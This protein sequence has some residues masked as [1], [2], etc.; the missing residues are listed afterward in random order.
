MAQL[1]EHQPLNP[2]VVGLSLTWDKLLSHVAHSPTPFHCCATMAD[3]L[4][5]AG[6]VR[7]QE[8]VPWRENKLLKPCG[9]YYLT[10]NGS[11]LLAFC[12][13]GKFKVGNP[14]KI[15]GAHTDS[16]CLRVSKEGMI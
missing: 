12:I 13:G 2:E 1:V 5:R 9:K 6:F 10:R 15:V 14:F 16:P 11:T 4:E 8:N 7:L 3:E